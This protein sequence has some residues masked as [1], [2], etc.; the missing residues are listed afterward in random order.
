LA[1]GRGDSG[2]P[3]AARAFS[4]AASARSAP[5]A[6]TH[7]KIMTAKTESIFLM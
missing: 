7:V 6:K 1:V 2:L 3:L 5:R 4:P